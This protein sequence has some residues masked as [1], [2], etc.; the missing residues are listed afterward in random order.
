VLLHNGALHTQQEFS[1]CVMGSSY[2]S[3]NYLSVSP[4]AV[5]LSSKIYSAG[6]EKHIYI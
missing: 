4:L 3:W 2:L 5:N 6:I 1:F